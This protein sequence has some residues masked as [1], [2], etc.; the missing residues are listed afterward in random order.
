MAARV[1]LSS[2]RIAGQLAAANNRGVRSYAAAAVALT[3]QGPSATGGAASRLAAAAQKEA[4]KKDIFW[5]REPKTG[6]WMPENHFQD[7]DPADLRA[8]LLFS[9][10]T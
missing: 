3:R 2:S 9:K 8:R 4:P 10:K 1:F 6:N 5:M 7:V